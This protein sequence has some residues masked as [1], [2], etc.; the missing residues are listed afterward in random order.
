K[1]V[2]RFASAERRYVY[3]DRLMYASLLSSSDGAIRA[4]AA[5][6]RT[7]RPAA[8]S[9][10]K[11]P[12]A[13]RLGGRTTRG[14]EGADGHDGCH[15]NRPSKMETLAKSSRIGFMSGDSLG[16]FGFSAHGASR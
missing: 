11:R 3:V 10:G 7:P 14:R 15:G 12:Q 2:R 8:K 13:G 4:S 9:R 16:T 6:A 1:T 5:R